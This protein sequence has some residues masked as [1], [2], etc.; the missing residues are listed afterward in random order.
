MP[1]EPAGEASSGWG[2]WEMGKGEPHGL[3]TAHCWDVAMFNFDSWSTKALV[4]HIGGLDR[5]I[6]RLEA[7]R[8]AAIGAL[9]K[10]RS[11][12]GQE[13]AVSQDLLSRETGIS[14]RRAK[15]MTD[16][17][18]ALGELPQIAE[19]FSFGEISLEVARQLVKFATPDR[20]GDLANQAKDWSEDHAASVARKERAISARE[21]R[22]S[23]EERS[24]KWF[25]DEDRRHINFRAVL[26]A[27]DGELLASAIAR[28]AKKLYD[29]NSPTP[30]AARCADALMEMASAEPESKG[31]IGRAAVILV[32]EVGEISAAAG[33]IEVGDGFCSV[34]VARRLMCDST[35]QLVLRDSE[36]QIAA[37]GVN[38]RSVPEKLARVVRARDKT[39]QFPGCD[40]TRFTEI[41]H[42]IHV[43]DGGKTVL[44]NLALIC[45]AHHHLIHEGGW[46]LEGS[47]PGGLRFISPD[48]R[49]YEVGA[50][51]A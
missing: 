24:V 39:C 45:F 6:A 3:R 32:A 9:D 26:P 4:S 44:R 28:R 18:R 38:S 21:A 48:G 20:D 5:K 29:K 40:K 16:M 25:Y 7:E 33:A 41:H 22:K 10:A 42:V 1:G 12:S 23:H 50:R 36:G 2:D 51:A 11:N 49:V 35:M 43:A 8:V 37:L 34:D 47:I 31:A 46:R 14:R 13:S 30:Y 27:A 17:S 19:A 15:E